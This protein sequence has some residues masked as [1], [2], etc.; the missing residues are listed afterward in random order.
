[1]FKKLLLSAALL[2][3]FAGTALAQTATSPCGADEMDRRMREAFPE[4][5]AKSE[6]KLQ[7]YLSAA[8]GGM[9]L[10]QYA[11]TTLEGND[12]VTTYHIPLVFH[13]IHE[14]GP[15]N[16]K[17]NEIYNSV[18]EI[19][20]I[21]NKLNADT[22]D[23]LSIFRRIRGTNTGYIGKTKFVFHLAQ[24]DPMGQPTNGITRRRHYVTLRGG[25]FGKLD[26]WARDSYV[27]IWI[28]KY[29]TVVGAAAYAFQPPS[30]DNPSG[31][32]IDGVMTGHQATTSGGGT[33]NY[34]NTIA[35]EL[36]H[37][38]SLSHPWG[39]TNSPGIA[40]GD[41][42]VDD[43]P[44]TKGQVA[45]ESP[46]QAC[47]NPLK[48]YDSSCSYN[49]A[50]IGK[51]ALD[52]T[53]RIA[54]T[55]INEGISFRVYTPTFLDTVSFYPSV[56]VNSQYTIQIR[57][58]GALI[59]SKSDSTNVPAG[60]EQKVPL[61]LKLPIGTGF[62]MSFAVNPGAYQDS[63]KT[64]YTT[65][66]P[67]A[68]HFTSDTA[69][70]SRFHYFH[71]WAIRYGYFKIYDTTTYRS[72]YV[73]DTTTTTYPSGAV[74]LP[75][76]GFL[77]DYPDTANA[78]NVMDYTYCSKM[79]THGQSTRMR[80]TAASPVAQRNSLSTLDNL[81]KTGV[82]TQAGEVAPRTDLAPV[83]DF[84]LGRL[85]QTL[86]ERM[87]VQPGVFNTAEAVYKC[88]GGSFTFTNQS[89]RDTISGVQWDFGANASPATSTS[90]GTVNVTFNNPGYATVS[91]TAT[92]NA[93]SNTI[94]RQPVYLAD[95]ANPIAP[96]GYL[97]EFNA[98][99]SLDRWP[100]FNYYNN[101]FKWE[102]RT[103]V[104]MYDKTCISY[105]NY[106][107][108]VPNGTNFPSALLLPGS[109]PS[110][111]F[112]DFFS[113]PFNLNDYR[114]GNVNL[115]FNYSNAA[116]SSSSP[117]IRD[118]LAVFASV[119]CGNTWQLVGIRSKGDL[120]N[121][122]TI[123]QPFVPTYLGQW[124]TASMDLR[125]IVTAGV[126]ASAVLFRFRY[127]PGASQSSDI[128]F[129]TGNNFYMDR[130]HVSNNPLGVDEDV[131]VKEGFTI[132]PNPTNGATSIMLKNAGG[133]VTVT[134]TD[135]T[136]KV[137]YTTNAQGNGNFTK[138][139]V[140]ASAISVRGMYLV[141]VNNNGVHQ[142]QKL[143][144]N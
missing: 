36:G 89:N 18:R 69:L 127:R 13:I 16:V 140:P 23:V 141:Q 1:M 133:Q 2:S 59:S 74:Y 92:S 72:L 81:K 25:D 82:F 117:D 119:D 28:N 93:G 126:D 35:H 113:P 139:E 37:V 137:V 20:E 53:R 134:V 66:V 5:V 54:S 130:L 114:G 144:V 88:T 30:V 41:D 85:P 135:I 42:G 52:S 61:G 105:R 78:E 22:T 100:I 71:K 77:V 19:N 8:L 14:Y 70:N 12:T 32:L 142:T 57:Q 79:F 87:Y 102:Y 11:K 103:D 38:F 63:V 15:E 101:D 58:N 27:N 121:A 123:S 128:R 125:S 86:T 45:N 29:I 31:A 34:D 55:S 118:T 131:I 96:T 73:F 43:T 120:V 129:G 106:D 84:S 47:A 115:N 49:K 104:G 67:G 68:L 60:Q 10:N 56:P 76:S 80:I 110:G 26:G 51:I 3:G 24:T 44:P 39:N 95:K 124:G 48:R 91:L 107:P 75:N 112:D 90:T 97:Q 64:S 99:Q 46:A 62:T 17:D 122:G 83:A 65:S 33:I 143:V 9:N 109:S 138:I 21:F 108:R 6:A 132:A 4:Q 40:C 98:D 116:R 94:T 111:D 136:G 7:R 50:T